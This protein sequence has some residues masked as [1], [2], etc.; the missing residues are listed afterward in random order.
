MPISRVGRDGG[1]DEGRCEKV[2]DGWWLVRKVKQGHM[3]VEMMDREN[4]EE[5]EDQEGE[6]KINEKKKQRQ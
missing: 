3:K 5:E 2:V 1:R 6:K 4:E